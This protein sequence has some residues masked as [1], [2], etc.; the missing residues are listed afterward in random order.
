LQLKK[1]THEIRLHTIGDELT[2][3][4]LVDTTIRLVLR[5]EETL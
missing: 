3:A 2:R 1:G 5:K 4:E